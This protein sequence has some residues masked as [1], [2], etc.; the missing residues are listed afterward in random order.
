[1]KLATNHGLAAR[2]PGWIDFDAGAVLEDGLDA[3]A[4]ALLTRICAVASGE[5]ARNE[6]NEEREIALWKRGVTL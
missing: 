2:K 4:A 6:V 3:T 1:M 5:P